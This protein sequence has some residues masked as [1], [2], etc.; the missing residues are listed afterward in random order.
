MKIFAGLDRS[1][2]QDLLRTIGA[3]LDDL[4]L[5][6]VRFWEYEDGLVVQGR[7]AAGEGAYE[8]RLFTDDDLRE[9]L[10]EAYHRR[11]LP[12]RRWPGEPPTDG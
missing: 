12:R 8:T 7:S 10:N 1:D 11:G 3:L 2:Y 5:R 9:L 6:D 4:E